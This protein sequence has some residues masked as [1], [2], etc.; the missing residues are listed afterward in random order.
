MVQLTDG[1]NKYYSIACWNQ[2]RNP[3]NLRTVE[4]SLSYKKMYTKLCVVLVAIGITQ[5]LAVPT[6]ALRFAYPQTNFIQYLQSRDLTSDPSHSVACMNYFI[7]QINEVANQFN[8]NFNACIEEADL[9]RQ[10]IDEKTSA[11]RT[12]INNSATNSCELLQSCSTIEGSYD[13]FSCYSKAVS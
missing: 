4:K 2:T 3:L 12:Q 1:F 7:P 8:E 13:F 5:A 9:E 11:N 10:G 6:P